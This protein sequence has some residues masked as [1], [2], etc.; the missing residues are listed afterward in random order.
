MRFLGILLFLLAAIAQEVVFR[1]ETTLV[2]TDVTVRD[3]S[4]KEVTGLKKEDFIVLE[5]GKPQTISVFEYQRIAPIVPIEPASAPAPVT[6]PV[7]QG[8]QQGIS[9]AEPGRVRYQDRRLLVMFFDFSSMPPADQHR[10]NK[11]AIEFIEKKMS[12]ADLVSVMT[13]GS[14]LK[15]EQDFT[16]DRE[17]LK[18]VVNGFL[19]GQAS[20]LAAEGEDA[21]TGEET[22]AA[23]AGDETE[24]NIFNTDRKLYA[25]ESATRML[26]A[27]PERKALVYFSSGVSKTGAENQ[28]QLRS[29][30]NAAVRANVSF[31]PVD[32]RG[33]VAS[34]P[35]GD[36]SK[37]AP[38]GT[39]MFSGQ[40]QRQQREKFNNQQET[41]ATLAADT[42]G[43]AFLDSNDLA[44]GITQAQQDIRSYYI[45]GYYSTNPARDGRFRRVQVKLAGQQQAKLDYRSGYFAPK[46]FGKFTESDKEAQ[47]QDALMLGDPVTDLP[48]ALEANYFRLTREK[49]FVP[50]AM[51]I[52]GSAVQLARKGAS[53]TTEFDFIGQVRDLKGKIAGS[54]RDGIR[55]KLS[56]T[57]AEQ[58]NSRSLQYDTGFTLAPGEYRLKF[59]VRENQTGKMGTFETRLTIPDL[60]AQTQDLRVS[61]LVLASQREKLNAAVGGASIKKK[62]LAANPLIQDGQKLVPSITRVFRRDQSL[63]VYLE[64]YG[65]AVDGEGTPPSVSA[66]LAFYRG[67]RKA[68][69]SAPV[70]VQ[71][72]LKARANAVPLQFQVPLAKVTPGNYVCQVNVID[73]VGR[74]FAFPRTSMVVLP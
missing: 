70:S 16:D 46:D 44:L 30:V 28:S 24:F 72:P 17:R 10:A 62:V 22:N 59:L 55:V 54:V 9:T 12:P 48:L 41:L 23:F 53:G 66:T 37:A 61:S 39:S 71:A 47:L 33:L 7:Q 3:R 68:F 52:P 67:R 14:A 5:D 25:L 20:E 69:E 31:Y 49:Y 40:A 60:D 73:E 4:G 15:V 8:K 21:E 50:V 27:L 18:E 32:T 35:G 29:T 42:G 34:I 57:E 6:I 2:V 63:Y 43:K 65:A 45:I 36:A 26:A 51:K 38:R 11:A 56:E 74:K 13:F 64:T 58:L 19:V 1:T